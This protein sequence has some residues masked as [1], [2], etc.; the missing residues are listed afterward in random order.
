MRA[1]LF[2]ALLLLVA[3]ARA[4]DAAFQK[5]IDRYE[6]SEGGTRS[7]KSL[8]TWQVSQNTLNVT[9]VSSL[10][11][12]DA[13]VWLPMGVGKPVGAG[14]A[15]AFFRGFFSSF[16]SILETVQLTLISGTYASTKKTFSA[17]T[18]KG[19]LISLPVLQTFVS[20]DGH[21]F[22]FIGAVW[23]AT[24]FGVQYGCKQQQ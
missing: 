20:A 2:A 16:K 19:C 7:G 1:A 11:A 5:L 24:D 14:D 12:S 17:I 15:A 22:S 6:V 3:V 18:T 8:T 23:N 10:L 13:Q 4:D 21:S 9:L